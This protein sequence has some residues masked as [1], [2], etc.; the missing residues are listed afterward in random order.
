MKAGMLIHTLFFESWETA[1]FLPSFYALQHLMRCFKSSST[2][3]EST[4]NGMPA[5]GSYGSYPVSAVP[6]SSYRLS[7]PGL[8]FFLLLVGKGEMQTC[9]R[10]TS[11]SLQ[12]SV[13][14]QTQQGYLGAERVK[15]VQTQV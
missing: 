12:P 8:V 2:V 5:V 14:E 13:V 9:G 11:M 4:C 7:V 15:S 6:C 1:V 3:T 10:L